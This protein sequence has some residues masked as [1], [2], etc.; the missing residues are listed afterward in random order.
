MDHYDGTGTL[1]ICR[2]VGGLESSTQA[3]AV[4]EICREDPKKSVIHIAL[5]KPCNA[6]RFEDGNIS[7]PMT[8]KRE[9]IP[10]A[11]LCG[12][13]YVK[14]GFAEPILSE[15]DGAHKTGDIA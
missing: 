1:G 2:H 12:D 6:W 14:Y 11:F 8:W 9:D 5:G 15:S 7:I 10:E 3:S 13:A 4:M